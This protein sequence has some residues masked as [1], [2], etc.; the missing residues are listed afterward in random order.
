VLTSEFTWCSFPFDEFNPA[1]SGV[2]PLTVEDC[3]LV[4]CFPTAAGK[5]AIAECVMAYQIFG[6]HE[7]ERSC[8]YVSPFKSIAEEKHAAW[9]ELPEFSKLKRA[10]VTGDMAASDPDLYEAADIIVCSLECLDARTRSDMHYGWLSLLGCAVFDE[11]QL[12]GDERGC[13]METALMR[14]TAL[15]PS[16]RIVLLSATLENA[17]QVAIWLKSLNGKPTK[18]AVSDWK[19]VQTR[20]EFK[21]AEGHGTEA[22]AKE[23]RAASRQ[24]SGRRMLVFVHSKKLGA[25]ICR[26]ICA[27]GRRAVFHHAG[28]SRSKRQQIE[29]VF[30]RDESGRTVL[31]STSTLACGVNLGVR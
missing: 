16:C 25:L 31:V 24:Y 2:V 23:V 7:W 14:L 17:K 10:L 13:H 8:L 11:S 18:V 4:V 1:Q 12:L 6:D 15:S 29:A 27:D 30:E 20:F 5:T 26:M 21:Q 22:I 28:L 19:P 9:S 3:N